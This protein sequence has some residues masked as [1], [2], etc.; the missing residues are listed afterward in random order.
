[1]SRLGQ[2]DEA[3]ETTLRIVLRYCQTKDLQ[4]KAIDAAESGPRQKA[5]PAG[6]KAQDGAPARLGGRAW[7]AR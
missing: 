7:S 3:N 1:M 5:W 6:R 2:L 4:L